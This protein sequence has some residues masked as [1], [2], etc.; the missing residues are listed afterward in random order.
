MTVAFLKSHFILWCVC[1]H[2]H[3][4]SDYVAVR[5]QCAGVKYFLPPFECTMGIALKVAGSAAGAF[6]C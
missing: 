5:G 3:G 2:T 4:H 1:S 6:T